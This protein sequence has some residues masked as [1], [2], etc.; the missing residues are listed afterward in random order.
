MR[1][2]IGIVAFIAAWLAG[3]LVCVHA[4]N[5]DFHVVPLPKE[6]KATQAGNFEL[7]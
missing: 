7:D 2:T 5:A 3:N 1:K 6:V 4:Q